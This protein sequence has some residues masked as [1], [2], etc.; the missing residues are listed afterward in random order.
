MSNNKLASTPAPA[1]APAPS[2]AP[3]PAPAPAAKGSNTK[4]S[5][6]SSKTQGIRSKNKGNIIKRKLKTKT[7]KDTGET[8]QFE[9]IDIVQTIIQGLFTVVSG[10]SFGILSIIMFVL[11]A[12]IYILYYLFVKV[13]PFIVMYIGIP[14]FILGVIM[15]LFFLGGHLL[16]VIVFIVGLFLYLKNMFSVIYSLPTNN[17]EQIENTVSNDIK[18]KI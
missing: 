1:P 18:V 8:F 12:I 17:I 9:G 5:V 16:F 2:P 6:K 15:G 3:A 10:G 13:I 14:T 4:Q 11:K 7:N